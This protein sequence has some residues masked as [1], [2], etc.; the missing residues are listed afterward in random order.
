MKLLEDL[1]QKYPIQEVAPYG[2]CI[3]V[4]GAEFDP[5]NEANLFDQGYKCFDTSI[6]GKP[7][8]LVRLVKAEKGSGEKTVYSPPPAAKASVEGGKE[9]FIPRSSPPSSKWRPES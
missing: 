5:D 9:T 6:D 1:K 2:T 3:V 8:T 4:P 7:V